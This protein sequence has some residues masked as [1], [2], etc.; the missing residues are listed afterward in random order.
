MIQIGVRQDRCVRFFGLGIP[1]I[2]LKC[3]VTSV[4]LHL[5]SIVKA[6]IPDIH[7][8]FWSLEHSLSTSMLPIPWHPAYKEPRDKYGCY[9]WNK[10]I[11][12]I[13][14]FEDCQKTYVERA[15]DIRQERNIDVYIPAWEINNKRPS[16]CR[17]AICHFCR[18]HCGIT[19]FPNLPQL[20]SQVFAVYIHHKARESRIRLYHCTFHYNK[21]ELKKKKSK[22]IL[23]QYLQYS[24]E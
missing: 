21:P 22:L 3:K 5:K 20:S 16:L 13:L 23:Q 19:F 15:K 9:F 17:V 18:C 14:W 4:A 24:D 6:T 12:F 11:V 2:R 8:D 10:F 7:V 1:A